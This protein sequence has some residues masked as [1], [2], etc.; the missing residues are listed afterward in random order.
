MTSNNGEHGMRRLLAMIVAATAL[1][2][3]AHALVYINV[4]DVSQLSFQ[5][6]SDGRVYLRNINYFDSNALACCYSYWIDTTTQEGKNTFAVILS[7]ST[8]QRGFRF[9]LTDYTT[10][11]QITWVGPW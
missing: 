6:T 4:A 9:V 7:Y 11:Q 8:L 2:S 1:I 3:P 5:M 10:A